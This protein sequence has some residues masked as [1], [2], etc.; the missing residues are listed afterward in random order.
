LDGT[1]RA[2]GLAGIAGKSDFRINNCAWTNDERKSISTSSWVKGVH[3]MD[4]NKSIELS[5]VRQVAL[6]IVKLWRLSMTE[7]HALGL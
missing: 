5:Q 2:A 7:A 4:V 1:G 6:L 3:T